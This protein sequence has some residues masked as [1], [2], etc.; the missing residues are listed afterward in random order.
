[1]GP[2]AVGALDKLRELVSSN[3]RIQ[4][5]IRSRVVWSDQ[6]FVNE[7]IDTIARIKDRA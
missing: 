7:G 6:A 3:L 2:A 5:S 1:M 4:P